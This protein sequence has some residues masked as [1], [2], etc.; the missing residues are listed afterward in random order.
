M[1][2]NDS[3]SDL[4]S[5]PANQG[6]MQIDTHEAMEEIA[7]A[8]LRSAYHYT[9]PENP[10]L[11][12]DQL[13]L[14]EKIKKSYSEFTNGATWVDDQRKVLSTLLLGAPGQGKTTAFKQ[15]AKKVAKSLG[16]RY[17]ENPKDE[18]NVTKNDF[19]FTSLEFSAEN[20]KM[21][22]GGIPAKSTIHGREVMTRLKQWRLESLSVAGAGLLL[23][24]DFPNASPNIQNLGLSLTDEKRYQGLNLSN[25]YIGLTGNMGALDGTHTTRLSTALR[26]RCEIYYTQ[27]KVAN[28][29]QRGKAEYADELGDVGVLSFLGRFEQ[30]FSALPQ[31]RESGGFVSPRTWENFI[32]EARR[33]VQ[34]NGGRGAGELKGL[35]RI[36]RKAGSLLGLE[37]GSDFGTFLHSMMTSAEPLARD[38]IVNG[39]TDQARLE[40]AYKDGFSADSQQFGYQF[41]V[42]LADYASIAIAKI[43]NEKHPVVKGEKSTFSYTPKKD[44]AMDE[45]ITEVVRRLAVGLNHVDENFLGF[46]VD[47]FKS[48]VAFKSPALADGV[49][50]SG[51]SINTDLKTLVVQTM[52]SVKGYN[53]NKLNI[54]VEA[55]TDSDKFGNS[56]PGRVRQSR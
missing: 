32:I 56:A 31:S 39:V 34:D 35:G 1:A 24:D 47:N 52:Q 41:S 53:K 7:I 21:E 5:I 22:L 23:L 48:G 55:I 51:A 28:F 14:N 2:K 45:A 16:L 12:A 42:A 54:I 9:S 20:S 30:K 4:N 43:V 25:V 3:K 38:I 50:V 46:S 17:L 40:K 27:D 29:I 49:S 15:A 36:M 26:G 18:T 8:I 33:I 13:A 44:P 19:V 10:T 11:S 6:L 37:V